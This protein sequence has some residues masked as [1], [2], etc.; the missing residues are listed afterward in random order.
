MIKRGYLVL[1][2]GAEDRTDRREVLKE[3]LEINRAKCVTVI[4]SASAYPR[5]LGNSYY[6]IFRSLGAGEV[7]VIDPRD[8]R[9]ADRKD[10]FEKVDKSD[11]IFFTGGDQVLLSRIFVGTRLL[12]RIKRK[13]Y[14]GVT[15]AGTSAGAAVM[16]NPLISDGDEKGFE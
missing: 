4:P 13:Y 12:A 6:D 2:G 8:S 15:I 10:F 16:S 5:E 1:I 14:N 3:T 7:H 9:D 11:M